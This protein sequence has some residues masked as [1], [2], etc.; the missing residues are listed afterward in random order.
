MNYSID[1]VDMSALK[2]LAD[3]QLDRALDACNERI[4]MV[5]QDITDLTS[6]CA[7]QDDIDHAENYL[8]ELIS[9]RGELQSEIVG[10]H[11]NSTAFT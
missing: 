1:F 3:W 2:Q 5:R 4:K 10:R 8:S 7:L 11:Q 6:W 9:A